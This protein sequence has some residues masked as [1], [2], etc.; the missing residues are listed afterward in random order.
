MQNSTGFAD[1]KKEAFELYFSENRSNERFSISCDD[2][3]F[4][5]QYLENRYRLSTLKVVFSICFDFFAC[6]C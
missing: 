1:N 4:Y 2:L 6:A 5:M 3:I